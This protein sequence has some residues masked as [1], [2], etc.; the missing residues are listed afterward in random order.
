MSFPNI[1]NDVNPAQWQ[2]IQHQGS[3]LLIVAGPGTGKTHTLTYRICHIIPQL[4]ANQRILAITFTNKAAQEMEE[5]LKRR[6]DHDAGKVLVGTFHS[7][8]LSWIRQFIEK[9]GLPVDFQIASA[10]DVDAI[11]SE[12]WSDFSNKQKKEILNQ[13]AFSKSTNYADGELSEFVLKYNDA[14]RRKQFLDFDDLI[15]ETIRLL[16]DSEVVNQILNT[17]RYCFVDEYQDINPVQHAFLK[18]LIQ[19]G[20]QITAIG[21]PNQAIYGFRGADVA[22]FDHFE[23]DF[24][25]AVKLTLTENYRSASNILKAS[26]Q[27]MI[28][29]AVHDPL[30]LTA[31]IFKEGRLT[32]HESA[33]DKAE[34][35]YIVHQIEKL[36]GG[37]TMFSRDSKRVGYEDEPQYGFSDIAILYRLNVQKN[38]LKQALERSGIPYYIVDK[39]ETTD[40][41]EEI[42]VYNT[43]EGG[44]YQ[45]ECV[46]CMTLHAA[47]GLEFSVVFIIGC[48]EG[49][50]PLNIQGLISSP[51]EDRR[52]FY[53]G[54]TRAK[55]RLYM[56]RAKKRLLFGQSYQ[57]AATP[58]LADI[59]EKLKNYESLENKTRRVIKEERQLSLFDR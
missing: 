12:L 47:K 7:V 11:V 27:V 17:Y 29:D 49:L 24:E 51:G 14:L 9:T 46:N 37:T 4:Q 45:P 57:N 26:G 39:K 41:A 48:E 1:P 33:T 35:E 16:N 10:D 42:Y 59:E 50:L 18:R 36:V 13:I 2:A 55:E 5:R 8:C 22:F 19:K 30:A 56:V 31:K 58:F 3:H 53:V 32:I 43:D 52:L 34:A 44:Q 38:L 20:V 6:L 25:G 23:K 40:P 28:K 21:D 54:M 15:L